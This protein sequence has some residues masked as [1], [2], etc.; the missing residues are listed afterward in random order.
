[1]QLAQTSAL[2]HWQSLVQN[3]PRDLWWQMFMDTRLFCCSLLSSDPSRAGARILHTLIKLFQRG[4]CLPDLHTQATACN[5]WCGSRSLPACVAWSL[6][7]H[8]LGMMALYQMF[9][10]LELGLDLARVR[11]ESAE[12]AWH[13]KGRT[14]HILCCWYNK[15]KNFFYSQAS[16]CTVIIQFIQFWHHNL[17]AM[18]H[19]DKLATKAVSQTRDVSASCFSVL[20]RSFHT[21]SPQIL[22]SPYA[23]PRDGNSARKDST[24]V[25]KRHLFCDSC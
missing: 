8:L 3:L 22:S 23:F 11:R 2:C 5:C 20:E 4:A 21:D 10:F 6:W 7:S 18:R 25:T 16:V 12:R 14:E 24:W 9:H 1:M 19:K 15:G 17:A 13:N